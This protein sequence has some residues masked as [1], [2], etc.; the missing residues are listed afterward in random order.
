MVKLLTREYT[1][2]QLTTRNNIRIIAKKK[3]VVEQ[4]EVDAVD[5]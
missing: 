3:T 2:L 4:K 1:L 5:F